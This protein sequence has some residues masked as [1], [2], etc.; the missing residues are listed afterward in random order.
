MSTLKTGDFIIIGTEIAD[1]EQF[2]GDMESVY[3]ENGKLYAANSGY[4]KID[5]QMRSIQIETHNEARRIHPK[6]DDLITGVVYSIRKSAVGV[7]IQTVNDRVAMDLGLVG[8]IH[9]AQV[10]RSYVDK[11]DNIFQKTDMIRAKVIGKE[12]S[13]Y[14]LAT[15]EPNLGVIQTQ[16][17]YCGTNMARKG[18]GQLTCS[19][20]G[21]SERKI[22][23]P[24]YGEVEQVLR[25]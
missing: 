18:K 23:A 1:A 25:F 24:D 4:I 2:I 19:F 22:I 6:N 21:H 10:S 8:N 13:E 20:C 15:N 14:R 16:C 12:G 7:L 17:K 3:I 9:I 5:P 11:L